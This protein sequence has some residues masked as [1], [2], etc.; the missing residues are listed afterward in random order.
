MLLIMFRFNSLIWLL[1]GSFVLLFIIFGIYDLCLV[2][3]LV[4]VIY[5]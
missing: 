3:Y 2:S 1:L 4:Y 5:L